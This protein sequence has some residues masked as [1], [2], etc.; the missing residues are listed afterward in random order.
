[1]QK[2]E[3]GKDLTPHLSDLVTTK[4]VV[5]PGAN[6]CDRGKDIDMVLTRDGFII[7]M[8]GPLL[9]AIQKAGVAV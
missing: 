7:S 1:M 6:P 9:L 2:V 5:L 3:T 8:M 4:G